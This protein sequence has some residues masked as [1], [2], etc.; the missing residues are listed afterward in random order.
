MINPDL[1]PPDEQVEE[2]VKQYAETIV[3]YVSTISPDIDVIM[4]YNAI[5]NK[6]E[7]FRA[8]ACDI[9]TEYGFITIFPDFKT[10]SARAALL[11]I[12]LLRS[13][14]LEGFEDDEI[15]KSPIYGGLMPY[16]IENAETFA[17][18][19]TQ[20]FGLQHQKLLLWK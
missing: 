12:G 17:A 18:V 2:A 6:D 15:Q 20:D 16:T 13:M 3:A 10:R 7:T 11:N 14:E 1:L 9:H 5:P 19:L 8:S 4:D